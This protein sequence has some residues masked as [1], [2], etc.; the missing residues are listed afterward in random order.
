MQDTEQYK[1]VDWQS[2]GMRFRAII[3]DGAFWISQRVLCLLLGITKANLSFHL[4]QFRF[5]DPQMTGELFHV[6]QTEGIRIVQRDILHYPL[7]VAQSVA[8]SIC[9]PEK[10]QPA[11]EIAR[12]NGLKTPN[13]FITLRKEYQFRELLLGALAGIVCV[14]SQYSVSGYIVD[15]Y[16]P[17][18]NLAIEYDERHHR[19][20][21][22]P[23][24]ARQSDIECLTGMSFIRVY[25]GGEIRAINAIL[26]HIMALGQFKR[27]E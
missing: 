5:N 17:E 13:P 14:E 27:G 2:N 10:I 24:E 12:H 21:Q 23:D 3:S 15:F 4:R 26:K 22:A 7:E 25:E 1:L 18:A 16:I 11:L 20:H 9:K 8:L 19:C 6:E